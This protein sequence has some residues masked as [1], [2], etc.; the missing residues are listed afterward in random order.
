MEVALDLFAEKGYASVSTREIAQKAGITEMTLFRKFQ[1]KK[2]LF[3]RILRET[4]E[5]GLTQKAFEGIS[6]DDPKVAFRQCL[7]FLYKAFRSQKRITKVLANSPEIRD[8]EFMSVTDD[9]LRVFLQEIKDFLE[10]IFER[11]RE[12]P[13]QQKSALGDLDPSVLALHVVAHLLGLFFLEEVIKL[14]SPIPWD[15]LMG[16]LASKIGKSLA[17]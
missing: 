12:M 10:R 6:L 3:S 7:E 15:T 5:E 11:A 4:W 14:E 13:G 16:D 17:C 2:H 9:R 8:A 1:T